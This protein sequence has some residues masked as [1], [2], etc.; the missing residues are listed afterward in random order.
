MIRL[1]NSIETDVIADWAELSCLF[2]DRN[3]LS[4]SKIEQAFEAA[5]I[6]AHD[7]IIEAG[8]TGW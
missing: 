3:S 2:G 6:D 4:R 8:W 7:K 5:G 1:P